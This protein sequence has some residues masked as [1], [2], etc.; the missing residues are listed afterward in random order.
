MSP[1]SSKL[2]L[3]VLIVLLQLGVSHDS[4][5]QQPPVATP[6]PGTSAVSFE[7]QKV[8]SVDLVANPHMEVEPYRHLLVQHA[9]DNYSTDRIKKTVTALQQ[10]GAFSSVKVQVTP[11][12]NGLR[13]SF[14]L[15]PAYYIGVI[16]FP[17][18]EKTFP[19]DRL[20]QVV[21]FP[22]E[23]AFDKN[24]I[25][26]AEQSLINFFRDNGYFQ[27]QVHSDITLDDNNQ[28]AN[29][30]F[31]VTLNKRA[32]IGNIQIS[33]TTPS[34]TAHLL[35]SMRTLRA[36]I[37]GS[38]LKPGKPYT[39]TRIKAG[40]AHMH[41]YLASQKR[42]ASQINQNPPQFHPGNNHA[43][44]SFNVDVGPIVDIRTSGAKL[45]NIGFLAHRRLKKLVPVYQE[46]A[47]DRQL[48]ADGRQN[49]VEHFQK[50]GYFDVK[51]NT[52]FHREP[53]KI[54]VLYE[55]EKGRKHKVDEVA[56]RGDQHIDDDEL[57]PVLAI[58]KHKRF[59]PFSTGLFSE[60]LLK[61]SVSNIE[62]VYKEQGYED[63]KVNAQVVDKGSDIDIIFHIN[64]GQQTV[65][66]N[67]N[68]EGNQSVSLEELDPKGRLK[69]RS[70][71]PYSPKKVAG[72][73][74]RILARYLDRGYL[75]ADV[76]IDIK[77]LPDDPHRVDITY[78]I[79][80]NQKVRISRVVVAGQK[81]TR[82]DLIVKT[83]NVWPETPLSQS[84]LLAGESELYDLGIFDWASVG[85]RRPITTQTDEQ[86]VVK[87]HESSRNT[88]S[89]GFG[90]EA[91]RRGGSL[92]TGTV[93][94]PGL[95]TVGLNTSNIIAGENTFFSPRGSIEYSRRNIRGRAE[96][97]T[98]SL[99]LSRLDQRALATYV[100]PH[101]RGSVWRSLFSLSAER[102]SQNPLF[103][104]RLGD[105]SFQLERT[106][107]RKKTTTVQLR[108]GFRRT[109]LSE[110]LIP[111][112]VLP[113]DRSVRLST[114]SGTLIRD[115]RDRP[116]D[117]HRGEYQ[118]LDLGITPTA[119]G[120]SANFAKLLG[121]YARYERVTKSVVWANSIR[122]GLLK[123]FSGD[124]VPTSE[125]F[126]AGGGST[127]RGFPLNGAG[128]QRI[129]PVCVTG[130]T[131]CNS[132][133]TVPVG[134]DQ[135]FIL[136][137]E[138]RYPI[139]IINNLG[140]VVF[141]DGG[142]VYRAINFSD[143]VNHY[144]NTVGVGIRYATPVGP[145]R[146]DIGRN[147]NPVPGI[148]PLQFTITLG[149]AF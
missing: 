88:I 143:F 42:L 23:T 84:K 124:T 6:G 83:A 148:N 44:L 30:V 137:S 34:E 51:V 142:N 65:V 25:P 13:V 75:N 97:G 78:K 38:A 61:Q 82:R 74:S 111:S 54:S 48:V 46:G 3:C 118:T 40:V 112:L 26:V 99:L 110:I 71:A 113:Q 67:L 103:T 107:D 128:P 41:N 21:N 120:S 123:P 81:H 12:T 7:G 59:V 80:E 139:P 121:Q 56:F 39:P 141:Y 20:L 18:A 69:L 22:N 86:A 5:A 14:V 127:L 98:V 45:A 105:A 53:D 133:I 115:T 10:T 70:G 149:Q 87:V 19:Y 60:K 146:F 101:F 90:F 32:K 24:H 136:N 55:I 102:T 140:G 89:Y 134:G 11:A 131:N 62:T 35:H 28:L 77:R 147:L 104:A 37:T 100:D 85:P 114:V 33:G 93:A 27:A 2:V 79:T 91:T 9:N 92:P 108:Y 63:V 15:E 17:G 117:P 109:T 132:F 43:D 135:L 145:V 125:R 138:L 16:E 106:I 130:T 72:D 8:S 47:I 95:P 29:V 94:I 73:R 58:H 119:F 64:E 96:T 116:L 144:T 66:D 126:F 129:A 36:T 4:G 68:I 1:D 52:V 57:A 122:L 76:N 50:H 49:I 31:H